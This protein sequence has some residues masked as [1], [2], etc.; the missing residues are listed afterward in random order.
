FERQQRAYSL[1]GRDH[2]RARQ[3]G[4]TDD[5]VQTQRAH[6]RH[7][8]EQSAEAGAEGARL[9]IE[10]AYIGDGGGFRPHDGGTFVIASARQACEAFLVQKDGQRIDADGMALGGEL[11]LNVVDREILFSQSDGAFADE[12]ANRSMIRTGACFGEECLA[13]VGIMAELMAEDAKGTGRVSEA[14]R[15]FGGGKLLDE[16]SGGRLVLALARRLGGSEEVSRLPIR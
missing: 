8:D 9:E 14:L 12:I 2:G 10:R 4:L 3:L 11:T 13:F 1:L 15:D 7:E 5:F 6:Q 16:E